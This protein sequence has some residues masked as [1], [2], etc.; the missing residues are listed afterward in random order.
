MASQIDSQSLDKLRQKKLNALVAKELHGYKLA[1]LKKKSMW[2]DLLALIV[3]ILYFS[4]R[5]VFKDSSLS[6]PLDK[7]WE[8]LAM[9]LIALAIIKLAAHWQLRIEKHSQLIG[10]NISSA[11]QIDYLSSLV[12]NGQ[13]G[14]DA[15]DSFILNS[16]T[17]DKADRDAL[18]SPTSDELKRASLQALRELE[19]LSTNPACPTCG[20]NPWHFT[21]GTCP[22]CGNTPLSTSLGVTKN[23]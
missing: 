12:R 7:V 4:F 2:P 6:G 23:G 18:G 13:L 22:Q 16:S 3:P 10:D 14:A 21:P 11:A 1:A 17:M 8:V 15:V 20:A 19:P 9:V 5:Y